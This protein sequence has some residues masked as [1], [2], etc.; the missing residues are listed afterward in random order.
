MNLY[1]Q[2]INDKRQNMKISMSEKNITLKKEYKDKASALTMVISKSQEKAKIKKIDEP[3]DDMVLEAI[4]AELKQLEQ[5]KESCLKYNKKELLIETNL[6][7]ATIKAY[8]PKQLSKEELSIEIKK[9]LEN[10]DVTS[11]GQIMK[12]I[13]P[14]FKSKAD[15]RLINEVVNE[16]L[17][18]QE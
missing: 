2:L 11:K 1:T 18:T 8:M 14:K 7:M 16:L 3:T 17:K 15:G 9:E 6:K 4:K 5:T 10:L 12:T 13:M